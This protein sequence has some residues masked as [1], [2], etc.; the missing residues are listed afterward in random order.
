MNQFI[1]VKSGNVIFGGFFSGGL[2]EFYKVSYMWYSLIGFSGTIVSALLISFLTGAQDPRT[3]D[4][5]YISPAVD[6]FVKAI[7]PERIRYFV[8]WDLGVNKVRLRQL[9]YTI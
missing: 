7:F 2:L 9:L 3:L 8:K 6:K 4:P 1:L 5:R